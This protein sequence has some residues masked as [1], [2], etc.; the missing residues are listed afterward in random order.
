MS[1][2]LIAGI[3]NI[4]SDE[5]LWTAGVHP[6]SVVSKIPEE[7]MKAMFK[8]TKPM[9]ERGIDFGGDSDSDYRNIYGEPGKFQNKHNAIAAP[10]RNA[11]STTAARFA[12]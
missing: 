7:K 8:A 5:I 6:L 12:A 10:A 1:Q 9:L 2:D 3:G 4:Y 11:R